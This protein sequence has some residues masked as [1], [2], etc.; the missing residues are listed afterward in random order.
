MSTT[1]TNH[2]NYLEYQ[3]K[4]KGLLGWILSTD[5]KRIGLLYLYTMLVQK[6]AEIE[7]TYAVNRWIF[8]G[9]IISCGPPYYYS[10]YRLIKSVAARHRSQISFWGCPL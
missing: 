2:V 7:S 10:I 1:T 6:I 8:L 9:L 3:G 5:H 4:Y